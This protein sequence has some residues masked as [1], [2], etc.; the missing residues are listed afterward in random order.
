[1]QF[2]EKYILQNELSK[3]ELSK[4]GR[5]FR[6][7]SRSTGEIVVLKF[8]AKGASVLGLDRLK[9]ESTFNFQYKGLP[10][11]I[12]IFESENEFILVRNFEEGLILSE[13]WK[14]IRRREKTSFLIVLFEKL[15][16]IF[17][18]LKSNQVVHCDIRPSNIII[19]PLSDSFDVALIDFGLAIRKNDTEKRKTLFPL[20]FAAPELLLNELELVDQRTDLFALGI[21]AYYLLTGRLPLTH[22]NPSIFTNLQLTHPLTDHSSLPSGWYRI[23]KK[24]TSKHIFQTSPNLLKKQVIKQY[25]LQGMENRYSNLEA[26]VI[27]LMHLPSKNRNWFER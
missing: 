5:I 10:K 15:H 7:V 24:M 8:V 12:E 2:H 9:N 14:L 6:G 18:E 13:Y 22:E 4:F 27:E 21:T 11:V 20:G 16:L 25:L 19:R 3:H 17:N 23:L 26:V 1:M